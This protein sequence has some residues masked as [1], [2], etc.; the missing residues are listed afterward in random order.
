MDKA[1]SL[2]SSSP[3]CWHLGEERPFALWL[4]LQKL[5]AV[6]Q[7]LLQH[8]TRDVT[9]GCSIISFNTQPCMWSHLEECQTQTRW[10]S[11]V[12][13]LWF[14]DPTCGGLVELQT[15][16]NWIYIFRYF[17]QK[18]CNLGL[19]GPRAASKNN[20]GES[21]VFHK[22]ENLDEASHSNIFSWPSIQVV[23]F[24]D[25]IFWLVANETV[26]SPKSWSI[27]DYIDERSTRD[28][29]I[30]PRSERMTPLDG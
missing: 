2:S 4:Q 23:R 15:D 29:W 19:S 20:P 14:L 11:L 30:D 25:S 17:V 8:P 3:W 22:F 5:F 12:A 10:P 18:Y 7:L 6:L 9:C 24:T 27:E 28:G 13:Q 16:C 26:L 1:Y 21:F